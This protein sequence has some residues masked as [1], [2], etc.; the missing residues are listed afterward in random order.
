MAIARAANRIDK[1][2]LYILGSIGLGVAD[3]CV[4][5]SSRFVE[6]GT[7]AVVLALFFMFLAGFPAVAKG[8]GNTSLIQSLTD[9]AYRGRVFGALGAVNGVSILIGLGIAGA[10]GKVVGIVTLL[11]AGAAAGILGGLIA[12]TL[13]RQSEV[14]TERVASGES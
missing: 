8:A 2:T 4:F 11:S 14:G 3:L 12:L 6:R 13:R 9:D 10:L 7:P 5:N 1:R